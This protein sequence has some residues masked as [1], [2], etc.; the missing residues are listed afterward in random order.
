MSDA[1][2]IFVLGYLVMLAV[3][4]VISSALLIL[5][6]RR[7]Q[8]GGWRIPEQTLHLLELLGGWPASWLTRRAI[9]HKTVKLRYRVTFT[10]AAVGH[11]AIVGAL[12]WWRWG[13]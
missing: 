3:T 11:V 5:D 2:W 12:A 6:K 1:D 9:R 7:A 4:G 8:R 10:L 13:G